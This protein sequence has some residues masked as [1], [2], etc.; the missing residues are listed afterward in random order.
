[1][2]STGR[3]PRRTT[4]RALRRSAGQQRIWQL[5]PLKDNP[6]GLTEEQRQTVIDGRCA[7][8]SR[9]CA[10]CRS[11]S[12]SRARS[13]SPATPISISPGSGPMPR[14]RRKMR[15]TFSTALQLME[16]GER[17]PRQL[18]LPAS[19]SR[20]RTITRRSRRTIRR[21]SPRSSAK[22][23]A[24]A[25]GRRWAACGSSPTPTCRPARAWR[26]RCS[27][28]SAISSRS[29][30]VR[31]AVCW[32]PDCFGFSGAT[33]Q[34]LKPGRHHLVLHHQGQLERD[35]QHPRRPVLVGRARRLARPRT[36]LQQPLARL[37]RA[38]NPLST[39]SRRWNN[40]TQQDRHNDLAARGRLRRRRWRWST[41]EYVEREMQLR[42]FPALPKARWS[43]GRGLLRADA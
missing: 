32:L 25:L 22:A 41:P 20:R 15:R 31:H 13:R 33:P 4:S 36:H 3:R 43:H 37:Q 6:A 21:C 28:G 17:V 29:S 34:I 24:G 11:G 16:G 12:R 30:G 9:R 38:V 2:R 27:T 18:G 1:M 42:D 40:F 39:L 7:S 8:W 14:P 26:G 10:R 35:Q 23:A 19:T 5:P